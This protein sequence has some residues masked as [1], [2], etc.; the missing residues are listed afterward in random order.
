MKTGLLLVDIQNDYFTGGRMELTGMDA[1][2]K[3]AAQVLAFFRDRRWPI[4][5]IQHISTREGASFFLPGTKGAEI[6]AAVRPR[7]NEAVIQKHYPNSFRETPLLKQLQNAGVENVVICGAMS[8]M[9]IDATTRAA[10]DFG[11]GCTVVHD[12]CAT[13]NLD[14]GGKRIL[15]EDVHI[16][17]MAALGSAYA[18]VVSYEEFISKERNGEQ[19]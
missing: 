19:I 3:T 18:E 8:H 15:A 12:A 2:G 9:C 5:H 6:H 14:Y 10:A 11:F 4:F 13:R 17:F 7:P 16:S 1:A